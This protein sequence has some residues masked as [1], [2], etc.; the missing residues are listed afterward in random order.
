MISIVSHLFTAFGLASASGLNAYIPL[1]IVALTARFTTL[2]T[3]NPPFDVLT[4]G[5]VIGALI[6]LLAIEIIVD[7]IPAADTINDIIQTFIRP[8]AGAILFAA[9][10]NAIGLHP[11]LAAIL[12]LILAFGVHATKA[13]ARPVVTATTGGLGNA[14]VSVGEDVVATGVSLLAIIV[15]LVIALFAALIF[16][17]LGWRA[18]FRKHTVVT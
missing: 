15:P 7:K 6:V 14:F 3:L 1:L 5:W 16:I 4:S 2:I 18:F 13:T 11:V 17:W 10:T 8:T 9:S 12:G